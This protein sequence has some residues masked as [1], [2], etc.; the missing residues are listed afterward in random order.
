MVLLVAFMLETAPCTFAHA[1]DHDDAGTTCVC[2]CCGEPLSMDE[3]A[4]TR[5]AVHPS[6]SRALLHGS[7]AQLARD[8]F[9]A[10]F[11]P[12]KA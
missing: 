1:D 7:D 12:P 10:I 8:I 9:N 11:Q 6:T 4:A 2:V 5:V 3:P